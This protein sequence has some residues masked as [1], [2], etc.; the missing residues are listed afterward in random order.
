MTSR[1]T[2]LRDAYSALGLEPGDGPLAA[3]S[4]FRTLVKT[5]HPDVTEPTPQTLTQLARIVAAMELIKAVG[6]TGLDL[7]IS[8]N[9]AATGL[10]RTVRH[11]ERPLLVRIPAG[12]LDGEIIH[13]VGE[14]DITITI[15]ITA[16]EPVPESPAAPLVESAD[17]DAFIH[18]YSR[19][20]A[21]ARLARW[22]R[23]AQSAA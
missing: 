11:G 22:I 9:Q 7:E 3:K 19:P 17:L 21:H 14:P 1:V 18:E 5:L 2:S 10:T 12:V 6:P 8:S 16:S 13:A 15:R 20:S 4:A 23:K